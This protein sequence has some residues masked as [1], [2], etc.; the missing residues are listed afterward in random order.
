MTPLTQ[1]RLDGGGCVLV[2]G[3]AGPVGPVKAGRA[4]DLVHEVP[5]T[6]QEALEPITRAA[7]SALDQLR[8]ARPDEITIEFGVDLAVEAGAVITK[9]S[10]T[11][12]LQVAMSWRSGHG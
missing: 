9:G 6:F 1:I 8:Q 10:A 5:G 2:E 12:H 11:C 4:G 7:Q 3:A